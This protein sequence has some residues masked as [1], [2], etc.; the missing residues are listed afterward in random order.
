MLISVGERKQEIG[1]RRALG[2]RKKDILTQFL[3]ESV[4]VTVFGGL[5]GVIF[6][7]AGG[8]LLSLFTKLSVVVS[9]EPFALAF[10]F[11]GLVGV[12]AGISPAKRAASLDPIEALRS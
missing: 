11:S 2:A 5:V 7:L 1:L 9:W 4:A 3:F 10:I 12:L 8:K 6:G